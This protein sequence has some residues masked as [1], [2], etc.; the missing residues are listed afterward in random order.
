MRVCQLIDS[1]GPGGAEQVFEQLLE[2]F[3]RGD[4]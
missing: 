4:S 3:N 1:Y 2:E